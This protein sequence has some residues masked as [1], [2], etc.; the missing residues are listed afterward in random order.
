M[1][2]KSFLVQK[3]AKLSFGTFHL[4]GYSVGG[5][6]TV[7]QAP[8]FNVCFDFGRCPFFAL[9]SDIVCLS[10]S[11]MDHIAGIGYYLSQRHFQGMKPGMILLPREIERPV[12]AL[13]RAWRDVERQATP[14]ELV[15]MSPGQLFEVRRDF[16]IRA[17]ATHHGGPSLGYA[18]ISIREKLKPELAGLSGPELVKMKKRGE[19]IQY[20]TEIPTIA[21][22]GDTTAGPVFEDPDV[23]NAQVLVTECTFFDDIHRTKAKAGRHLHVD[24]F[25]RIVPKLKNEFIIITHV[26]RRT[27]LRRAKSVLRRRIGDEQMKRI[28]FL[29][30]MEGAIDAGD[31]EQTLPPPTGEE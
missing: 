19:E 16:G 13:L 29:M 21:F 5:E 23:Q 11:H 22:L 25:A 2:E 3:F 1:V 18:L 17:L 26:S 15:P 31:V 20:R 10:H 9:T 14:Y 28:H 24:D 27:G 30:D 8:E 6:E 12:D 7:V 4:I